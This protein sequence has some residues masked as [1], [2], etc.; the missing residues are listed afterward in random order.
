MCHVHALVPEAVP[1]YRHVIEH[2]MCQH[3]YGLSGADESGASEC[4]RVERG[5]GKA[6]HSIA[7]AM[8]SSDLVVHELMHP[9]IT[10]SAANNISMSFLNILSAVNMGNQIRPDQA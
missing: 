5:R 10:H 7:Q 4:Y 6:E 2:H 1:L 8:S 9:Y 3:L